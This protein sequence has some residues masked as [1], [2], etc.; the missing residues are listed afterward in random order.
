[1]IKIVEKLTPE[2]TETIQTP[3]NTQTLEASETIETIETTKTTEFTKKNN[4]QKKIRDNI[5]KLINYNE[6]NK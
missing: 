1:M 2:I 3:Q 5:F 6:K 4:L